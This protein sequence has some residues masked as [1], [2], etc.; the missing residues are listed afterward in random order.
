MYAWAPGCGKGIFM[1]HRYIKISQLTLHSL[2]GRFLKFPGWS[3]GSEIY[4]YSIFF[5]YNLENDLVCT[6]FQLTIGY[7]T[8]MADTELSPIR[9]VLSYLWLTHLPVVSKICVSIGPYNGFHFI[10]QNTS[11]YSVCEM[12]AILSRG[13]WV[14]QSFSQRKEMLYHDSD[15][16]KCESWWNVTQI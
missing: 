15:I 5:L 2:L 10:H 7:F 8:Y 3:Q 4:F 13:R 9:L 14:K 16:D 11:E 12:A 6:L 1:L